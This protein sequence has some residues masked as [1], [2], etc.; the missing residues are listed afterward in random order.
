MNT[1]TQILYTV[2]YMILPLFLAM[3]FPSSSPG[4][5]RA[6]PRRDKN[7]RKLSRKVPGRTGRHL[8]PPPIAGRR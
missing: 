4:I 1:L 8:P 6:Q 3:V 5:L 7:E 2:S